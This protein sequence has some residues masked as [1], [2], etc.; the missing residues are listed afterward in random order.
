MSTYTLTEDD[1]DYQDDDPPIVRA[2]RNP[3]PLVLSAVINEGNRR[4]AASPSNKSIKHYFSVNTCIPRSI[5]GGEYTTPLL[6]AIEAA[7][8]QNVAILLAAGATPDGILYCIDEFAVRFIRGRQQRYNASLRSRSK[9]MPTISLG[10]P[11]AAPLTP[12]EL[13]VRRNGLARFWTEHQLP[14]QYSFPARTP[15]EVAAVTGNVAIFD[16]VRAAGPDESWWTI[17]PTP[18]EL[19]SEPSLSALC[20][21]SPVHEAIVYENLE[22]LQ[23][24]LALGFSPNILPLAAPTCCF[25]PHMT[26]IAFCDPPNLQAYDILAA[27]PA[28]DLTRRTPVYSIHVLH[29]AVARLDIPLVQHLTRYPSTPLSSASQTVLGHTLL[30]IATLPTTDMHIYLF[31]KKI[32]RSVHDVRTLSTRW[33]NRDLRRRKRENRGIFSAISDDLPI[34]PPLTLRDE[35]ERVMQEN[36]VLWL[37]QSG[38]QD[39]AAQD[40]YGNTPLHYLVCAMNPNE[41]LIEKLREFFEGE[42]VWKG[43]KNE[44]GYTPED[45]WEDG[46]TAGWVEHYKEFWMDEARVY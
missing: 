10:V 3:N 27:H 5:Y 43:S 45:L 9:V 19:P 6:S 20:T 41:V 13:A 32:F 11:Q 24:L 26:A 28:V 33:M 15:L 37:L 35:E 4:L 39:L 17:N 8:P 29:I 21:S 23:H 31:S 44:L 16:Q 14:A 22:M 1:L 36:M 2:A 12:E 42:A 34:P 30:H 7:L 25:P 18:P 40:V 38:T 46:K